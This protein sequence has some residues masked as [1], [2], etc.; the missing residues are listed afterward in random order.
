M[1][2]GMQIG[3]LVITGPP[4]GVAASRLRVVLREHQALRRGIRD[5]PRP[6]PWDWAESRLI[7]LLA[8]PRIDLPG[9]PIV[10]VLSDPG[11]AL[12]FGLDL[13]GVLP[14]L[15]RDVADRWERS[16][17]QVHRTAMDNL[18]RRAAR[19]VPA[20]VVGATMSGRVFRLLRHP[21]GFASSL[22]LCPSEIERLFGA[23]DQVLVAP[24]SGLLLSFPI[25]TPDWVVG[26]ITG[27]FEIR[28]PFP[29]L[30]DP[31]VYAGGSITWSSEA[32][33]DED[34]DSPWAT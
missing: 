23:D 33:D 9:E 28:E 13:G 27:E 16:P 31:F 25:D 2:A 3:P 26:Q 34:D 14:V 10:R 22:V 11:P 18:R 1:M 5:M 4:L 21:R 30:L 7:P 12:V 29:L 17:E 20:A 6:A 24:A 19:V 8:G 32:G 15:D